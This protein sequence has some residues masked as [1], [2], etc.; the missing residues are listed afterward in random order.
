MYRMK[1]FMEVII[2][3]GVRDPFDQALEP[4]HG[5]SVNL[6]EPVAVVL[7]IKVIGI[8]QQEPAGI[9]DL[10]VCLGQSV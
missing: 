10:P 2:F 6:L 8:A 7:V 4:A 5:P 9:P 3:I 1:D